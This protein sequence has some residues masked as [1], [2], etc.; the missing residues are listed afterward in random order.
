MARLLVEGS[1][2]LV[3]VVD[4]E[5]EIVGEKGVRSSEVGIMGKEAVEK[6]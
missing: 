6:M 1:G 5:G 4:R 2:A 3:V